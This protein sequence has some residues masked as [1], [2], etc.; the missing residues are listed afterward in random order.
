LG[1]SALAFIVADEIE[2][3]TRIQQTRSKAWRWTSAGE[4]TYRLA[5]ADRADSGSTF[6]LRLKLRA[7]STHT[8]I[9][10]RASVPTPIFCKSRFISITSQPFMQFMLL[11]ICRNHQQRY[12]GSFISERF[13]SGS[14][15]AVIPL[16]IIYKIILMAQPMKLLFLSLE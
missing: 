14:L 16:P 2:M 10:A 12:Y 5:P 7:N 4:E 3:V 6:K 9:V 1:L 15:S 13:I 8:E 11:G